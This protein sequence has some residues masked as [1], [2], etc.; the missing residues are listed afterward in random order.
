MRALLL[1]SALALAGCGRDALP[2]GPEAAAGPPDCA[3]VS[4]SPGPGV[5][6]AFQGTEQ[7]TVVAHLVSAATGCWVRIDED[8]AA[9]PV[10][11]LSVDPTGSFLYA[12]LRLEPQRTGVEGFRIDR[13]RGTLEPIGRFPLE[14]G[15]WESAGAL[16]ATADS[17]YTITHPIGTGYHG[18]FWRFAIDRDSG[19]LEWRDMAFRN[20]EPAFLEW[21]PARGLLFM[22]TEELSGPPYNLIRTMRVGPGGVLA[23]GSDTPVEYGRAEADPLGDFLWMAHDE[24]GGPAFGTLSAFAT[25]LRGELTARG[26]LPWERGVPVAHPNGRVLY[27]SSAARIESFAVD[28][29]SGMPAAVATVAH[30][31][32]GPVALAVDPSGLL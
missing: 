32:P 15:W 1:A 27:A 8:A 31:Q 26:S 23:P 3:R 9:G 16:V 30:G 12:S 11:P 14:R 5:T 17:V 28:P 10:G 18:G 20:R 13:T 21:S 4:A 7:G 2:A 24:D 6:A 19:R 22:W 29:L 25:G